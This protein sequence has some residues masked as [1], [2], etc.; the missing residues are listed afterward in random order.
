MKVNVKEL[1]ILK[2]TVI[3]SNFIRDNECIIS[4]ACK[5]K[6]P[7]ILIQIEDQSDKG[8]Q[9]QFSNDEYV[10]VDKLNKGNKNNNIFFTN[11][12]G[13]LELI[14]KVKSN[15]TIKIDIYKLLE[16]YNQHEPI[17]A[18][19]EIKQIHENQYFFKG[20]LS[21]NCYTIQNLY[22]DV[23]SEDGKFHELL[24]LRSIKREDVAN[25]YANQKYLW[26]G[27]HF[28]LTYLSNQPLNSKLIYFIQ[29]VE[30]SYFLTQLPA[31]TDGQRIKIKL[32][33]NKE[34]SIE[35][36]MKKTE[37]T[38]FDLKFI[39][40]K[41]KDNSTLI[42]RHASGG[43]ADIFAKR[44]MD[45]L[46]SQGE[47]CI[48]VMYKGEVHQFEIE[49]ISKDDHEIFYF[50]SL[51]LFLFV[52]K[53]KLSTVVVNEL[54]TYE[55]VFSVIDLLV[56]YKQNNPHIEFIYYLH[57]F[58]CICPKINLL[59]QNHRYCDV[60]NG[61][62]CYLCLDEFKNICGNSIEE[63]RNQFAILLNHCDQVICFSNNSKQLLLKAI[64]LDK[65]KIQVIPHKD[66]T[67]RKPN[68]REDSILTIGLLGNLTVHKG[69]NVVKGMIDLL[70]Q[71]QL[72]SLRFVLIGQSFEKIHSDYFIETGPYITN[73][74]PGLVEKYNIDV[75]F[76]SSVCSETYS[77]TASE[78]MMMDLPVVS[79]NIGAQGERIDLYEK[80]YTLP[81]TCSSEE[82]LDCLIKVYKLYHK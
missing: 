9:F 57:D 54:V 19:D 31:N 67:L 68:V 20:W 13:K 42:L 50:D 70:Q 58:Y 3:K 73:E 79:F 46:I 2:S 69:W 49:L 82:I 16:Y 47:S 44:Y 33:V 27:F 14:V 12:Q 66:I 25:V 60:Q 52:C 15:Q 17:G 22:L 18:I 6:L 53:D 21:D 48:S 59:D 61:N 55:E 11:A 32:D 80:G 40:Q 41:I 71:K 35:A 29:G 34:E 72:A 78:M 10:I 26:S 43:G 45:D 30:N 37:I 38:F 39:R 4:I 81:L 36:K 51:E 74:I 62:V 65:T 77:F 63:W 7:K 5:K 23:V 76:M 24:P 8:Y 64:T 75:F 28:Y 1:S 56:K